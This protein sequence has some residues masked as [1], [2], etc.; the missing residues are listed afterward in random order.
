[1][2]DLASS[3]AQVFSFYPKPAS[4]GW[5]L[6]TWLWLVIRDFFF[7]SIVDFYKELHQFLIKVGLILNNLYGENWEKKL[8]VLNDMG[9]IFSRYADLLSKFFYCPLLFVVYS[10]VSVGCPN[11]HFVPLGKGIT[12]KLCAFDPLEQVSMHY[13]LFFNVYA[14]T[15]YVMLAIITQLNLFFIV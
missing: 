12:H 8:E 11:T 13:F 7:C 6:E 3:K 15:C 1:M 5:L 2:P 9:Y 14:I 4:F 10:F